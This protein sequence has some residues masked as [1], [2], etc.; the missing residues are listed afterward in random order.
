[1]DP[2]EIDAEGKKPDGTGREKRKKCGLVHGYRIGKSVTRQSHQHSK[3]KQK[4][5]R[6]KKRR[7]RTLGF[8]R[9]LERKFVCYERRCATGF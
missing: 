7:R 4:E 3:P 1:M 5:R 2:F 9:V 6:K 8:R